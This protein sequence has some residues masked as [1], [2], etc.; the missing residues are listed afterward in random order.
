MLK[1]E[2]ISSRQKRSMIIAG[3]MIAFF[4]VLLGVIASYITRFDKK[5]AEESQTHLAEVASYVTTHMTSVVTNTQS[6][7]TAVA[8]A[9]DTLDTNELRMDYLTRI[10]DQYSFAY[11]GCAGADGKLYATVD[12]ESVDISGQD[13][14]KSAMR[15]ESKVSDL[16]RKIF[17]DRAVSGILLS[18]PLGK[19]DPKGVV[20]AM[21]EIPQLGEALSLE[22][23]GGEGYS[24]VFDKEGTII[25]RTQ[26]LDFNNLF[27]AW[28]TADFKKG[29]SYDAFIADI[30]ANKEGIVYYSYLGVEKIAYYYPIPFNNWTIVNIVP[31]EVVTG[32]ADS[33]TRELILIGIA[34]VFVFSALIFLVM[35]FY[36]ISESSKHATDAKSAFLASMS[37]EIRTPMNAIVGISEILLRDNLTSGQRG[38][39][40]NILN[41]GKGLL[42]IINDILDLSKIE[43]GKFSIVEEAYELESLLYDLTVIAA[44]RIGEKPVEFLIEMDHHLPRSFL[45][46]MGRV[47]QVLLNIVGNAIKFTDSGSIRLIISGT[48]KD[49]EW[50]LSMEVRD[51]GIGIKKEDLDQ[52]FISFNQVDTKRNHNIEGTGLGLVI[53][54][55]LCKLMGGA[56]T[57]TSEYGKGSSFHI[58]IRQK[59]VSENELP[60]IEKCKDIYSLLVYEPSDILREYESS[61]MDQFGL[62]Y[63][64]CQVYG[65]FLDKLENNQ[66]TH[67]LASCST[68]NELKP[69]IQARKLLPVTMYRLYEHSMID[70]DAIN[71]YIP[72]FSLLLPYALNG[73]SELVGRPKNA[74]MS[75]GD[76]YPMPYVSILVVDDNLVNIQVAEGLME[77]Y[78]MK[79]DHVLSGEEAVLAVQN[80]TYDLVLMDHMMP[81]IGGIEATKRIRALTREECRTIPVV[82]LTAN[83]SSDARRMFLSEGFDDFLSKPIEMQKLDHV[84]HK[85]LK[86]INNSRAARCKT[87]KQLAETY[88]ESAPILKPDLEVPPDIPSLEVDF[89]YGLRQMNSITTYAIVLT[90]YLESVKEKLSMLTEWLETDRERFIIEIHGLKSSNAAIGAKELSKTAAEL[91]QEGK[92][93]R[94]DEIRSKLPL[95]LTRSN[96]ALQEIEAYLEAS[97][98]KKD[99]LAGKTLELV[100]PPVPEPAVAICEENRKHIVIVDDDKVN[101]ELAEQVLEEE[102]HLTKLESGEALLKFLADT[103]PDMILLDIQMPGI[104]GYETLE[105]IRLHKEW[106][107]IPVIFLTGQSDI[108]S[109]RT[110]FR[111]GAK[112]FIKKPFDH[113]VMRSRIRSQMELYHYQTELQN[114]ISD[115]TELVEELQHVITMGWAEVIES[116]DGTTGSHVRHTTSY[117]KVLLD[118]LNET[119]SYKERISKES[120]ADLLRAS[121]L[122]DIGK[123]GISDMVL[124]K[125]G[126]LTSQEFD[127]MKKHVNIGAGMIQKI[128]D[129]T[130][131]DKFLLYAKDMALYHHERWDGTGYPHGLQGNEIP[132]YVQLL[133]I[134]D[135]YDAL[136]AVRP[137]KRAFTF[138]EAFDIMNKDRGRFYSPALFDLIKDNR[139]LLRRE[140]EKV[141]QEGLRLEGV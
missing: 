24:Y 119:P 63:D 97:K 67:V 34:I 131:P 69:V 70:M 10:A 111:L 129:G 23:F 17:T 94:F 87:E 116:R 18:V 64:M 4:I 20:V 101:R 59:V 25:M 66:Y 123:I 46:D 51:S 37:H 39:V 57:V 71:V 47:K 89:E 19:D 15:G 125:P 81:G 43:S 92:D 108:E 110:G 121:A 138:E 80:Q 8:A 54:L 35:R 140:L 104:S 109:E 124:K 135:I 56:I 99:P 28:D 139:E 114:I 60:A 106:R 12:S 85:Y 45:G 32:R 41:S 22:S 6:A 107:D 134:A 62:Q 13:Y 27:K 79:I 76:F 127:D 53:S 36:R 31:E 117:Y 98:P 122:H 11:I 91:E 90:T 29:Y 1:K 120:Q 130:R 83:A 33:L 82:A 68:L 113:V 75:R 72:L 2:P 14:F 132:L 26:R 61:C 44:I 103:K 95:F 7:L 137:Y 55:G 9:I 40:L 50:L 141:T 3:I 49:G 105:M 86:Q 78:H 96:R 128:I 74:S 77:P 133:T 136:T 42:T 38:K 118:L 52:L 84:L 48:K 58:T 102:Y 5:L 88:Q 93:G 112:D 126:P 30:K 73:I 100:Q 21:M 115:K 16:T 65:L